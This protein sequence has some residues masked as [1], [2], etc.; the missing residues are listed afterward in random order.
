[1]TEGTSE[2]TRGP[3]TSVGAGACSRGEHAT[4]SAR[5]QAI[6]AMTADRRLPTAASRPPQGCSRSAPRV[7]R[8]PIPDSRFPTPDSRLPIPDSRLPIPVMVS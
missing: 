2:T 7:P 5:A 1:M 6:T 8:S 4:N 3:F